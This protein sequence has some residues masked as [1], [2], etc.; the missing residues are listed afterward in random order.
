M[1]DWDD[2]RAKQDDY[3]KSNIHN[4]ARQALGGGRPRFSPFLEEREQALAR[5]SLNRDSCQSFLFFGGAEGCERM[6]LGVFPEGVSPEPSAFP[7]RAVRITSTGDAALS[8]RD[9]L[10]SLMA[11]GI[12]RD[13]IGDIAVTGRAAVVFLLEKAALFVTLNLT[14]IGRCAVVLEEIACDGITV[15]QETVELSGTV[16]SLRLDCVLSLLLN[17]SRRVAEEAIAARLVKVSGLEAASGAKRLSP[18]AVIVVRGVGKFILG[19]ECRK[20]KKDRLFITIQ[21]LV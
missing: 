10:G 5:Q 16:S 8:H 17:K 9:Y 11:L 3:L 15:E 19:E 6:V 13:C 20:T 21:K 2:A 7:I 14:R 18:G 1:A 4:Q 12:E